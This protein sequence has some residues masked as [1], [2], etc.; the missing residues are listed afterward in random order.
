[1]QA[2][3]WVYSKDGVVHGDGRERLDWCVGRNWQVASTAG[4]HLTPRLQDRRSLLWWKL[5]E[6]NR[7]GTTRLR[8]RFAICG[9]NILHPLGLVPEHRDKVMLTQVVR[10]NEHG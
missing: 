2:S 5:D 4:G 8:E 7:P 1:M 9:T 10:D 3:S 6:H